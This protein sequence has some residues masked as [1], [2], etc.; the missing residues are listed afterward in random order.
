MTIE[1]GRILKR[2][3]SV[4]FMSLLLVGCGKNT[5]P[6]YKELME[7]EKFTIV[8]V[9]TIEEY[10]S[11]HIKGAVNIPYES[12]D[13]NTNLDKENTIFVYCKS[14]RRSKI[15]YNTLKDLGYTVYD[16]GAYDTI[17]LEKE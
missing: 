3:I 10:T 5:Q 11:G 6:Y 13:E 14:G 17:E 2:I 16:L 8:D 7:K 1:R 12:I 9:R 15:A 4:I